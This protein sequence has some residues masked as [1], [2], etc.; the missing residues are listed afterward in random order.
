LAISTNRVAISTNFSKSAEMLPK[1]VE[2]VRFVI[3]SVRRYH[4]NGFQCKLA[5]IRQISTKQAKNSLFLVEMA[6]TP[7][8]Y[9]DLGMV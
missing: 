9:R 5:A 2:T 8:E 4:I 1:R 3:A 7:S 6:A